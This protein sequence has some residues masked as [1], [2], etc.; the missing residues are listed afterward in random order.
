MLIY[1][2]KRIIQS[3]WVY[4]ILMIIHRHFKCGT[5]GGF[6]PF[7]LFN[8]WAERKAVSLEQGRFPP[9]V[10]E[11]AGLEESLAVWKGMVT[12]VMVY[13]A[14]HSLIFEDT[15]P[16]HHLWTQEPFLALQSPSTA[17]R[18]FFCRFSILCVALV[19]LSL[20]KEMATHSSIL[21][22][23]IPWT[24]EPGGLQSVGWQRVGH[25]W[26]TNT[27]THTHTHSVTFGRPMWH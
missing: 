22:W 13:S 3:H 8:H 7:S 19:L 14:H 27:H 20:E 1:M 5:G 6:F 10:M 25:Y 9:H 12:W 17:G 24:E 4:G 26:V 11:R 15:K 16:L 23:R 2:Q 18:A 21:A